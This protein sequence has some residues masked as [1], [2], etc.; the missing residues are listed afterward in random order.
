MGIL[1]EFYGI[2]WD[3]HGKFMGFPW[4]L[5]RNMEISCEFMMNEATK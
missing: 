2:L 5:S 4:V 1:W 3:F